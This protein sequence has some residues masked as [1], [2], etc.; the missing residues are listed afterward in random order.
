MNLRSRAE[1]NDFDYL[2]KLSQEELAY[3]NAFCEG[4]NNADFRNP[5]TQEL[6][7]SSK[8]KRECYT[9]NNARNR[10]VYTRAK[11]SNSVIDQDTTN[12]EVLVKETNTIKHEFDKEDDEL[13]VD[14]L[15]ELRLNEILSQLMG[16]FPEEGN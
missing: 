5:K 14:E 8:E 3:L 2:E 10:C 4:W 16:D 9:M 1:L 15:E 13:S 6:F 11:A 12:T 7:K